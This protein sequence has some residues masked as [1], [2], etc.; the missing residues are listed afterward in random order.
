M[1]AIEKVRR[2]RERR[3]LSL[4]GFYRH[5]P[6]DVATASRFERGYLTLSDERVAKSQKLFE[7]FDT[8]QKFYEEVP[9]D[10]NNVRF[11]RAALRKLGA[12][13]KKH[14]AS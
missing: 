3:G 7:Q 6:V 11:V 1:I 12:A 10:F 4:D 5:L 2:E 8:L 13:Q 9:V 14:D